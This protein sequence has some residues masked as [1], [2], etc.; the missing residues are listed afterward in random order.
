MVVW[1]WNTH[2][3]IFV[4]TLYIEFQTQHSTSVTSSE[5]VSLWSS[6]FS[7]FVWE[8]RK[9]FNI[10]PHSATWQH[11]D[12]LKCFEF[13]TSSLRGKT[14]PTF[15]PRTRKDR[16]DRRL[17]DV[18]VGV[19]S[20]D[21]NKIPQVAATWVIFSP[22]CSLRASGIS[23]GEI[24][25]NQ[26]IVLERFQSRFINISMEMARDFSGI[27]MFCRNIYGLNW[28]L[29]IFLAIFRLF[30]SANIWEWRSKCLRNHLFYYPEY[31][32]DKHLRR[33]FQNRNTLTLQLNTYK[34]NVQND[35]K[36]WISS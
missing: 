10:R 16:C 15:C 34:L 5:K 14:H 3:E 11:P 7:E 23:N 20:R 9:L 8:K 17:L 30:Q 4:E 33:R 13:L 36:S 25:S 2:Q 32:Q 1:C 24:S 26:R 35:A 6:I 22:M 19:G 27:A 21:Y 28:Q 29:C 18:W 12:R 31:F